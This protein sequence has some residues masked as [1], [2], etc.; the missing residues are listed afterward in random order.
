MKI[1]FPV[2]ECV[3]YAKTGGLADVAAALPEALVRLGH[4]VHVVMPLYRQVKS[5]GV[6][7]LSA[8]QPLPITLGDRVI[9]G[10]AFRARKTCKALTRHFISCDEFF[11]RPEMYHSPEG[12][13]PDNDQ[14]FI[15]FCQAV[16]ALG[17]NLGIKWDIVHCH[18]WH[19]GLIPVYLKTQ[20]ARKPAYARARSLM[21]NHNLAFQ[22]LFPKSSFA[23]TGLPGSFFAPEGL[24]FWGRWNFL[25]AGLVYSDWINSVS[26]TYAE[27]IQTPEAGCGLDGVLRN[28]CRVLSG[29]LNG[30]DYSL[31]NPEED[32]Y[33]PVHFQAGRMGPKAEIKARLLTEQGLHPAATAPLI[34]IVGRLDNQKGFDI[35]AEIIGKIMNLNIQI[36]LLGTG[37]KKYHDLFLRLKAKFPG[38]MALILRFDNAL[39]HKIYAGSDLF[40][41]PSRYEP[42]GLGQMISMRYGSIPVVRRTGG[43]ADTVIDFNGYQGNGFTFGPYTGEALL[44]TLK[45]ALGVFKDK[46]AWTRLMKNAMSADFSWERSAGEYQ[47][48]Y[49]KIIS[50]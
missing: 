5:S 39:A 16:L 13:Y 41:M 8:S 36:I 21:T 30:V 28:R 25:K 45:H 37:M 14:R 9:S 35:L 7:L 2:S 49:Q 46:P 17:Q 19:T 48:L 43:L 18:D 32:P 10:R 20:S 50:Q 44:G 40:L 4:E 23:L 3:P 24:E 12:D 29:I 31:W 26:R 11:D 34:G 15:F 22:G 42:C 27:E 38:K 6:K 47:K 1:L 33:L